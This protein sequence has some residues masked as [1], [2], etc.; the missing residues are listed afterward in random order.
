MVIDPV[1]VIGVIVLVIISSIAVVGAIDGV[2]ITVRRILAAVAVAVMVTISDRAARRWRSL[3]GRR[4]NQ[5]QQ[6]NYCHDNY[7][8]FHG[9]SLLLIHSIEST[10]QPI[11]VDCYFVSPPVD[12]RPPRELTGCPSI[13]LT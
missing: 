5:L 1:A 10:I 13:K 6:H 8:L 12:Q 2:P 9:S 3:A 11:R 4:Q 7:D